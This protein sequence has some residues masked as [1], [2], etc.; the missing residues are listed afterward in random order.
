[1]ERYL[2]VRGGCTLGVVTHTPDENVDGAP[3]DTGRLEPSPEL[4]AVRRL[5]EDEQR[6]IDEAVRL[7]DEPHLDP[8]GAAAGRLL[9]LAA[10]RQREI[11]EPRVWLVAPADG[12]RV[13]VSELHMDAERVF[14]R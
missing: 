2:L 4:D 11:M 12:S 6:L 9:D 7:E 10:S 3:W 13:E 8:D 5:F 1:M 14:W